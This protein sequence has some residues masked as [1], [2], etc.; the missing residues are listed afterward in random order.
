MA[1]TFN[2]K[3]WTPLWNGSKTFFHDYA[4]F[5][6]GVEQ[7]DVFS[8]ALQKS[9][10]GIK[11]PVTKKYVG[12]KGYT[13]FWGSTKSAFAESKEAVKNKSL[14][15]VIRD[16][17]H[18]LP[19]EYR[20][21][22]GEL[23]VAGKSFKCLR[24]VGKMLGKR[25]PLIGNVLMVAMAVPNITKAFTHGGVGTGVLETGKEAAKL[26]GFA[27]GAAVGQALI[28]I[29]F[30][31]GLI[32]GI[33]GGWIAD[34]V[35]GKSYTEKEEDAQAKAAETAQGSAQASPQLA[36]NSGQ[37]QGGQPAQEGLSPEQR[38]AILQNVIAKYNSTGGL[39]QNMNG[40]NMGSYGQNLGASNPY[41]AGSNPFSQQDY[42]SEDLMSLNTFGRKQV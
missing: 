3:Y 23:G 18:N 39:S 8:T 5:V 36:D 31:G 17:F 13:D 21:I 20:A 4:N 42:M 33:V 15:T 30:V 25:M 2:A 11:D 10:R 16:S 24:S 35:V 14:G 19:G 7:S 37:A 22:K 1:V 40:Y 41:G 38:A 6:L 9:V 34:K 27:A 32:G 28:P 12:G 29:P 26:G